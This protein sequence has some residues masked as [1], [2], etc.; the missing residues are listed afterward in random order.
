MMRVIKRETVEFIISL[1]DF[2]PSQ[3]HRGMRRNEGASHNLTSSFGEASTDASPV[4][5]HSRIPRPV[6]SPQ[7]ESSTDRQAS[8][9]ELAEL[10]QLYSA[11]Q[12]RIQDLDHQLSYSKQELEEIN[13]LKIHDQDV[14]HNQPFFILSLIL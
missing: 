2:E 10:R 14:S 4:A 12:R 5:Y 6:P 3:Y 9:G 8:H 13:K 1:S 7:R 11:A